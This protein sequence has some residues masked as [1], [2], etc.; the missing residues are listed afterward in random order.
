MKIIIGVCTQNSYLRIESNRSQTTQLIEN[1]IHE[2]VVMVKKRKSAVPDRAPSSAKRRQSASHPR[3]ASRRV[4]SVATDARD[5]PSTPPQT[6]TPTPTLD[7]PTELPL[8]IPTK[9]A[10]DVPLPTVKESQL[11]LLPPP[12]TAAADEYQTYSQR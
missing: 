3:A 5:E 11:S 1:I 4:S 12:A 2:R 8:L 9:I 7:D 6:P 10:G